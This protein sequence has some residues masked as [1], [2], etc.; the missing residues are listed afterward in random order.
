MINN[1]IRNYQGDKNIKS[2]NNWTT[3]D[4]RLK[5]G[6][7]DTYRSFF[8]PKQHIK[9]ILGDYGETLENGVIWF[10]GTDRKRLMSLC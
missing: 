5:M 6:M 10:C 3:I 4:Y 2:A 9:A 7:Q 8:S 1:K